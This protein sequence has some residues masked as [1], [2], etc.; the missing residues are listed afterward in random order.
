LRGRSTRRPAATIAGSVLTLLLAMCCGG[1]FARVPGHGYGIHW[2]PFAATGRWQ[3]SLVWC[4]ATL[5]PSLPFGLAGIVFLSRRPSYPTV[6]LGAM[7]RGSPVVLTACRYEY[8][9]DVAKFATAAALALGVA[10]SA[11]LAW[12]IG[13]SRR[14]AVRVLAI[15]MLCVFALPGLSFLSL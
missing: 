13:S 3:S 5:G 10:S 9:W 14:V 6:A 8:S 2:A 12:G 4:A 7:A 15:A 1:F 11:A